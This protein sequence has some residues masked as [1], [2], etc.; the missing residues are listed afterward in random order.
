MRAGSVLHTGLRENRLMRLSGVQE[1][2][3]ETRETQKH[4]IPLRL[5]DGPIG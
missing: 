4:V 5:V 2:R 1:R 3:L